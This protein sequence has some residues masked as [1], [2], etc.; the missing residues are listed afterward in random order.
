MYNNNYKKSYKFK[1]NLNF[2]YYNIFKSKN[3]HIY[4]IFIELEGW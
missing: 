1:N 2:L 4:D 3:R